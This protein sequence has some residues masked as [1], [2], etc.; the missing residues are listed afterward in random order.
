MQRGSQEAAQLR[1]DLP[2]LTYM[3]A[4]LNPR[5]SDYSHFWI[6]EYDVDYAGHWDQFF[7]Q[8]VDSQADLIG[9]TFYP[10]HQSLDWMWWPSFEAPPTVSGAHHTRSFIPIAR[11]SRRMILQ[12]EKAVRG[13]E[14]RGH[15][16]ALL[17]TIALHHGFTIEDL[18]GN[19]PFTPRALAGKNYS[20]TPSSAL[21]RP[22]T[23]TTAPAN[24]SAYFH[25]AP[26]IF[27]TP[28]YLYHPVKVNTA[29][30]RPEFGQR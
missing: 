23:F 24:H 6:V 2:T 20:N 18:G 5:L 14:W 3:P 27:P 10:R 25:E 7:S 30:D 22:G 16:E 21:L 4:L 12:Y 26:E 19:G 11:F 17:P 9:T 29:A 8:F 1:P 13:G 28:E 15:V